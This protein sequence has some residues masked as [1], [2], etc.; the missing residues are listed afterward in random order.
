MS[1]LL[2]NAF[3]GGNLI[4]TVLLILVV[5]YWIVVIIGVLDFDFLDFDF[6]VGDTSGPFY[7]LLAF[8]K[9]GEIPFMFVFSILIL[10]FWIIAMLMYYLPISPGG[11]VNTILLL[12]TMILSIF[13]TKFECIPLKAMLK[14]SSIHSNREIET[15]V[16]GQFCTLKCDVE[17][18]RLG[19]AEIKREGEGATLIIN[20]KPE[21]DGVA[22]HK[23]EV[24][25]VYRKDTIKDIY[26]IVKIE[27][28][29]S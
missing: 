22:F 8:L 23:D 26:Y 28:V 29:L 18:G 9:V 24:A 6:D 11:T 21:F 4:P 14:N 20:V 27:G 15:I 10:N 17:N 16:I 5:L 13:I 19:Q 12:P 2:K 7:A 3:T 1:E 25:Y